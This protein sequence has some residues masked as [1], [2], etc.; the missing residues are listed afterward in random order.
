MMSAARRAQN[1]WQT[2][3]ANKTNKKTNEK[4]HQHEEFAWVYLK[5]HKKS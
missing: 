1:K 5:N 3:Y 2:H 4:A